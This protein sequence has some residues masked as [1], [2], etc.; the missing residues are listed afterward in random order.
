[1]TDVIVERGG[2]F[3]AYHIN[4]HHPAIVYVRVE[5]SMRVKRSDA[6][7]LVEQAV[8]RF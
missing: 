3:I 2:R 6:A 7:A 4:D 8:A 1:M 5:G